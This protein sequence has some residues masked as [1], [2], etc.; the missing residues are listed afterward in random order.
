MF[1]VKTQFYFEFGMSRYILYLAA[2]VNARYFPKFSNFYE[3][4]KKRT[5]VSPSYVWQNI[6][7]T[8]LHR[9]V[10]ISIFYSIQFCLFKLWLVLWTSYL[11]DKSPVYQKHSKPINKCYF[12]CF[13]SIYCKYV[14]QN[15]QSSIQHHRFI[16][17]LYYQCHEFIKIRT[18]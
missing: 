5:S 10:I 1:P 9:I 3:F 18:A 13:L 8:A 15:I 4:N 2:N 7:I 14:T 17:S 11:Q 6:A 16:W 12:L